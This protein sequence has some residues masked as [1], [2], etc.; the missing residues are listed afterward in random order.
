[1]TEIK[2]YAP[3]WAPPDEMIED[4]QG[5]WVRLEDHEKVRETL[6]QSLELLEKVSRDNEELR[7]TIND[8]IADVRRYVDGQN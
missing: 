1:M 6:R 3:V 8:L 2:R 5:E 7:A 4:P